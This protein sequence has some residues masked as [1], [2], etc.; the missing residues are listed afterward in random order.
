MHG[1]VQFNCFQWKLGVLTSLEVW[2]G[3]VSVACTAIYGLQ[4]YISCITAL[5]KLA[6]WTSQSAYSRA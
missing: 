4:A 3:S 6:G 5:F 1:M 2:Q